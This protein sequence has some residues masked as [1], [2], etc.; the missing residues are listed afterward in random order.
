MC[1]RQHLALHF[2]MLRHK[3]LGLGTDIWRTI[4]SLSYK[5]QLVPEL[6]QQQQQQ[7]QQQHLEIRPNK[8]TFKVKVPSGKTKL[9]SLCCNWQCEFY[10]SEIVCCCWVVFK[11]K[12][13]ES[14]FSQPGSH[15][16]RPPD[17]TLRLPSLLKRVF[18]FAADIDSSRFYPFYTSL[19]TS[20]IV[21]L[22]IVWL[23]AATNRHMSMIST[24][25]FPALR[26]SVKGY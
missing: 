1:P 15:I 11:Q 22:A 25:I 26:S 7:K 18:R 5:T 20:T 12:A 17:L 3:L 24:S 10:L 21:D 16:L 23:L 14:F 2:M 13:Q 6:K 9:I 4:S 19:P 8:N